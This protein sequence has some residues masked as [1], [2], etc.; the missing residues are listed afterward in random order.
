MSYFFLQSYAPLS[1]LLFLTF[2]TDMSEDELL[3]AMNYMSG[4]FY[5]I[6]PEDDFTLKS[7]LESIK[8]GRAHV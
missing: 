4:Y 6:E 2:D 1:T 3:L 8:I 5:F 7:I